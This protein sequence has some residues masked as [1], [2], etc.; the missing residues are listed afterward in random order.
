MVGF[1]REKIDSIKSPEET[2]LQTLEHENAELSHQKDLLSAQARTTDFIPK[3]EQ[4][5]REE[6]KIYGKMMKIQAKVKIL[7]EEAAKILK[8]KKS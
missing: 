4:I 7:K 1:F 8:K 5:Q 6:A 2:D 3:K